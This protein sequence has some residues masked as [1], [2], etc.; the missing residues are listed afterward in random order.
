MDQEIRAIRND[1][2]HAWALAEY[3]RYF[4]G[5]P[6][7]GTP[8]ADRFE[9]LGVLIRDYE[10]ERWPVGPS[11]PIDLLRLPSRTWAAARPISPAF[12]ARA[13]APRRSWG[14]SAR[15]RST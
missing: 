6:Q 14:A 7:A 12:S 3:E 4:D 1:A 10:A 2:D 11:D 15:L 8:D 13:H 5:E 9:V